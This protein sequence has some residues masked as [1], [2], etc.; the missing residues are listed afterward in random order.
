[1]R[2]E[3]IDTRAKK[4]FTEED[5]IQILEEDDDISTGFDTRNNNDYR[6]SNYE[7][8][9]LIPDEIS[10]SEESA[11]ESN[12]ATTPSSQFV[13]QP[14]PA[15]GNEDATS[16]FAIDGTGRDI[17]RMIKNLK[18]FLYIKTCHGFD[19]PFSRL[20]RETPLAPI[21]DIYE[22]FVENCSKLYSPSEIVT[23]DEMLIRFRGQYHFSMYIP[24][25]PNKYGIKMQCLADI[26]TFYLCDVFIYSG[27]ETKL[28]SFADNWYSY[29]QLVEE[30][31]K[32]K[33]TYVR[34]VKKN[35]RDIPDS[36][37]PNKTC[38]EG[39]SLFG[40]KSDKTVVSYVPKKSKAI[41]LI[42]LIHHTPKVD[43]YMGK[44]VI[45]ALYNSTT[46]GVDSLDQK[47]KNYTTSHRTHH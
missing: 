33:L 9:N 35:K 12:E 42:P 28:Q 46:S 5:I 32:Q 23:I 45:I 26:R 17:F 14:S 7:Q 34:T 18:M 6:P 43:D 27:K 4:R 20:A 30:L 44:P 24:T 47:C 31:L 21:F 41:V 22:Q 37:L 36:F 11:E 39:S 2:R 38:Q 16:L 29:V 10:S 25:K 13:E 8:E 40:F 19:N 15:P 3:R 1:M